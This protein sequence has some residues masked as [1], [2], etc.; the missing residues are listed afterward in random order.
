MPELL[1]L[2]WACRIIH[3]IKLQFDQAGEHRPIV[4]CSLA[5]RAE[6]RPPPRRPKPRRT[7]CLTIPRR[8]SWIDRTEARRANQRRAAIA[9]FLS[10]STI[11]QAEPA[12]LLVLVRRCR[13]LASSQIAADAIARNDEAV[14]DG[15]E[16]FLIAIRSSGSF[17]Q[18]GRLDARQSLSAHSFGNLIY[19]WGSLFSPLIPISKSTLVNH[20]DWPK[21]AERLPTKGL[22]IC[23]NLSSIAQEQPRQANSSRVR[24]TLRKA[25]NSR[26]GGP[27]SSY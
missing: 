15:I 4:S 11:D 1:S 10:V 26:P 20:R 5:Q 21:C 16:L 6:E 2:S 12:A 27:A 19:A 23:S 22:C 18:A 13:A 14:E 7:A 24:A 9:V 3:E 17:C 8:I 25:V